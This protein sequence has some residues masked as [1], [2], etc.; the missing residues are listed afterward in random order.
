LWNDVLVEESNGEV[1]DTHDES[2]KN[3]SEDNEE[4]SEKGD[5]WRK[6]EVQRETVM[7]RKYE[8]IVSQLHERTLRRRS[9]G[10][11]WREWGTLRLC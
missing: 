1:E 6:E 2:D 7:R 8:R 3:S 9:T 5:W 11:M 4:A 10:F